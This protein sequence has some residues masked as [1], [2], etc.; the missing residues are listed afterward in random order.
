VEARKEKKIGVVGFHLRG[1]AGEGV[2]VTPAS[3]GEMG[4]TLGWRRRCL[5]GGK[6]AR[7]GEKLLILGEKSY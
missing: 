4:K 5:L 2:G 6:T 7:L 3:T 1:G